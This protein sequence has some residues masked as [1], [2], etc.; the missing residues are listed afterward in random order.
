VVTAVSLTPR[1]LKKPSARLAIVRFS[2]DKR[3]TGEAG[4]VFGIRETAGAGG[5][6]G[7]RGSIMAGGAAAGAAAAGAA[8]AMAAAQGYQLLVGGLLLRVPPDGFRD[9]HRRLGGMV[10]T[11]CTK[12]VW[13]RRPKARFYFLPHQGVTLYC[14]VEP[15]Q[16]L[17]IPGALEVESL[18]FGPLGDYI[19]K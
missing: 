6:P 2:C 12:T 15:D 5:P 3:D 11:G 14:R 4:G 19:D 18:R 13:R 16:S 9:A 1:L 10:F 8:A 7:A 17:D